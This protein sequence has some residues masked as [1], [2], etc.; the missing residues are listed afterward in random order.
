MRTSPKYRRHLVLLRQ[1]GH[2]PRPAGTHLLRHQEAHRYLEQRPQRRVRRNLVLLLYQPRRRRQRPRDV[3]SPRRHRCPHPL[4]SRR[5]RPLRRRIRPLGR[6]V[7]KGSGTQNRTSAAPKRVSFTFAGLAGMVLRHGQAAPSSALSRFCIGYENGV[8]LPGS[9]SQYAAGTGTR[10]Y[11][12]HQRRA[13]RFEYGPRVRFCIWPP[14]RPARLRRERGCVG[15]VLPAGV[16]T[17]GQ[18][19]QHWS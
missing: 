15:V 3:P 2:R 10:A 18:H 7:G 5:H 1:A 6:R 4:R 13:G 12:E 16:A 9:V 19:A 8:T 11:G 14:L 17:G